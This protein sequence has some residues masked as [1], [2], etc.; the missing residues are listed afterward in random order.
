MPPHSRNGDLYLV[1]PIW[2]TYGF[3]LAI[4]IP[5]YWPRDSQAL[6]LGV[7]AWV[8]VSVGASVLISAFTAWLLRRPWPGETDRENKREKKMEEE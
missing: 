2:L 1:W 6:F 5:W 7:P 3:L 8:A 4:G